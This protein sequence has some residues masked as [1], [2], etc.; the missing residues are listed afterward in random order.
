MVALLADD[1]PLLR[2]AGAR[3]LLDLPADREDEV[4]A[5]LETEARDADPTRPPRPRWTGPEAHGEA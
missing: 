1:E 3:A 4:F 2:Q 5:L